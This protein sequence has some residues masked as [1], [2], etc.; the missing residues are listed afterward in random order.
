MTSSSLHSNSL[1]G[2]WI[3]VCNCGPRCSCGHRSSH[4]STCPCGDDSVLRRVLAE[5]ELHFYVSQTGVDDV[6][7]EMGPVPFHCAKGRPLQGFPKLWKAAYRDH[8][9]EEDDDGWGRSSQETA[10]ASQG[11]CGPRRSDL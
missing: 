7:N 3:Y 10:E 4:P 11:C 1:L 5:D 9:D 2:R 6:S 8:Q